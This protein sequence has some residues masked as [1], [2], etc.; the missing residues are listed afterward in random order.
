MGIEPVR[1][2]ATKQPLGPPSAFEVHLRLDECGHRVRPFRDHPWEVQLSG[3]VS[4]AQLE[5]FLRARRPPVI[6]LPHLASAP[7]YLG[8]R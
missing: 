8:A 5:S 1:S 2:R 4:D 7:W 6:P 3:H